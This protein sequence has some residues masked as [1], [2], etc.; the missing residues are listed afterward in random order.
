[1]DMIVPIMEQLSPRHAIDPM[2]LLIFA[3][4]AEQGSFSGAA[5]KLALPKSTI[6]R[7]IAA[8]EMHLGE[9]LL[10]RTTR[11]QSLSELGQQLLEHARQVQLEVDAV[12]DLRE[13]RQAA[14][15]GRLRVSM[16]NDIATLLLADSLAAFIGLFPGISLELDL[17]PRRVDLI[18]EGVDLAVRIGPL[19]TDSLLIARKLAEF[20]MG[21]YASASYLASHT[22][23]S[24][25]EQLAQHQGICLMTQNADAPLWTLRKNDEQWQGLA[26][27]RTRVNSP[28]LLI[29]LASAGVGITAVPHY[30]ATNLVKQGV[31]KRVLPEWCLP[32]IPVW[33]VFHERKLMPAKTRVF[34]EML[35]TALV[36]VKPL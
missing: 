13:R 6:S 24:H 31:L 5:N 26:N 1:M 8:L 23:P 21:L 16:P 22:E 7:R 36:Q 25:P 15:T 11:R 35:Q 27:G 28:E 10:V 9:K 18:A 33:A 29:Q 19:Q 3:Q 12:S 17:S 14:P 30:F 2:D 34:L 4:V 20:S 32:S